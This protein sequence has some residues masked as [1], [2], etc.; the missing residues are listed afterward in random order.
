M[1]DVSFL[2]VTSFSQGQTP[3]DVAD[4]SVE[5]LLEELSVK[6]ANV[7]NQVFTCPHS[8]LSCVCHISL[9]LFLSFSSSQWRN[10]QTTLARQKQPGSP[11]ANT[12]A[13]LRRCVCHTSGFS[14]AFT[15]VTLYNIPLLAALHSLS[16][17][18]EFQVFGVPHE[19]QRQ[20][21]CAGP[22]EG[23]GGFRKP[24]LS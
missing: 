18:H 5:K 24:A 19:Q 16:V 14:A 10:E 22:V 4:E 2:C 12:Q 20:D 15:T 1:F 21:H 17:F 7:R 9:C 6:Q 11:A 8:V 23:K 13:K 3:F